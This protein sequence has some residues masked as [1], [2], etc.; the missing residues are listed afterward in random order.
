MLPTLCSS[1]CD[2]S[3]RGATGPHNRRTDRPAA[4]RDCGHNVLCL[5]AAPS[6]RR[7]GGRAPGRL[8][9]N[10]ARRHDC[11]TPDHDPSNSNGSEH[12]S[13]APAGARKRHALELFAGLGRHYERAGAA[14]SFGQ[15]PRWR[16]RMVA[17]VGA[18]AGERVLDVAT[19]TGLVAR[20][21]VRRYDVEVVGLDQS[22]QMLAAARARLHASPALEKRITLVQG[23]AER[24]PFA[25]GEFDHLTFTYLLRYV[26]EPEATL[27]ELARVVAPGGRIASLEF[28]EPARE[29]WHALWSAYT[30]LGLPALGRLV[31]GDWAQV[32]RFL[33]T[34]IP[35]FYARHPLSALEADWRA[36][37]IAD[38]RTQVMSFG[39]GVVTTGTRDGARRTAG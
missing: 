26:D 23:Q 29:P 10:A 20:A 25:D 35:E 36:A 30:R 6:P 33:A 19:G 18:R 37:G 14:L 7:A 15:D 9:P 31:S 8:P 32:G 34:S 22:A 1:L 13:A 11:E 24:L 12:A 16:A 5:P 21:L 38:V 3:G 28:G 27:R 2:R 17:A 39:A 4:G